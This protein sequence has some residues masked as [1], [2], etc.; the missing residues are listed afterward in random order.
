MDKTIGKIIK[1]FLLLTIFFY[2]QFFYIQVAV[3]GYSI[4][5][6][7]TNGTPLEKIVAG[8]PFIVQ[9]SGD[10]TYGRTP[11]V[12][13]LDKLTRIRVGTSIEIINGKTTV[14]YSYHVI[15]DSVGQYQLGPVIINGA[16]QESNSITIDVVAGNSQIQSG[17]NVAPIGE[18]GS[19]GHDYTNNQSGHNN[20]QQKNKSHFMKIALDKD[21]LVIG[22]LATITLDFY[23]Q[24]NNLKIDSFVQPELT[25]L[26]VLDQTKPEISKEIIDGQEYIRLR[27]HLVVAPI[28]EGAL[29]IPA[30]GAIIIAPSQRGQG[31]YDDHFASIMSFFGRSFDQ[32]QQVYSNAITAHVDVLP[33]HTENQDVHGVG[34]FSSIRGMIEPPVAKE[35]D[36]MVFKIEIEGVADW[37]QVKT[38]QL[39]MPDALKYYDSRSYT[40]PVSGTEQTGKKKKVFEY[41]V[42]GM[43]PGEWEIGRQT[44]VYFDTD[45]KKYKT[46]TTAPSMVKIISYARTVKP[47][48]EKKELDQEVKKIVTTRDSQDNTT[49]DVFNFACEQ[50]L[51]YG[52]IN[53]QAGISWYIFFVLCLIIIIG[54]LWGSFGYLLF[55]IQS[56]IVSFYRKKRV[57]DIARKQLR[58]YERDD[59]CDEVFSLLISTVLFKAQLNKSYVSSESVDTYI[60]EKLSEKERIE[61]EN[62]FIRAQ[63]YVYG[64]SVDS[65]ENKKIFFKDAHIWINRLEGLM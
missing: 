13:G 12:T 29:T 57:W 37:D 39:I 7:S 38:P 48:E 15:A 24:D 45:D 63:Q 25:G 16:K 18:E 17:R 14:N 22:E 6:R 50:R 56:I 31:H 20:T 46:L 28:Q 27:M 1:R 51:L 30:F 19:D 36:A 62:F 5:A 54:G 2:T 64:K 40:E 61:W 8:Q 4:T 9:I 58:R 55:S 53:N 41:V 32:R 59:R 65:P 60:Q 35:L 52:T 26:R 42:Q 23:Y 10:T 34:Q 21:R 47:D 49:Q 44:F 43:R 3:S 11:S 33:V